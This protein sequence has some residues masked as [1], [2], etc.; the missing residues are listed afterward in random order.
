VLDEPIPRRTALEKLFAVSISLLLKAREAGLRGCF[1]VNSLMELCPL[2]PDMDRRAQVNLARLE[3]RLHTALQE[4]RA[5]GEIAERSDEEL[6]VLA[7]S[8][9]ANFLAIR[10]LARVGAAPEVLHEVADVALRSLD[11]PTLSRG[12]D[13]QV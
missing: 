5:S 12:R 3:G 2:D 9:M 6:R 8:L 1:M 4:A 10:L 13:C 11:L 7:H